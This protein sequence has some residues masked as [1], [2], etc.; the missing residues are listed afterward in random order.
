M[1]GEKTLLDRLRSHFPP[2]REGIGI[3]D[4]AAVVPFSGEL[5]VTTDMLI[6]GIDFLPSIPV[7]HVMR[8]SLA[9]NLSDLAAMGATPVMFLL[10]LGLPQ[11]RFS[12]IDRMARSLAEAAANARIE[13]AGGDLSSAP[14]LIISITAFGRL[15]VPKR[16]LLRSGAILGDRLFLSRPVG[17][18]AAGLEL[19]KRGWTID[20]AGLVDQPPGQS[21]GYLERDLASS[22]VRQHASPE[23]EVA[24]GPLLASIPEVH[25][26]IDV[27]DGLSTDLGHLCEASN[28]GAIVEWEKVPP[29]P[30]L[31]RFGVSSGIDWRH[32]MLHGGE[33]Y[34]LLFSSTLR[35]S[36]L[37]TRLGRP[38]YSIGRI[39]KERGVL[40]DRNGEHS[41]L[42]PGGYDHF[43]SS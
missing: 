30:D 21:F 3:G 36:Q 4:D 11:S 6:E 10:T 25:S 14:Q 22:A 8:K 16:P 2:L 20:A 41:P 7:E 31:E 28:V 15:A 42:E 37:S 9:A 29:M 24:L 35:E 23:A 32:C 5:V 19:L 26:C 39:T 18:S 13:L 33:E 27:S 12:E 17:G 34:A 1:T 40:L 43:G 38:V